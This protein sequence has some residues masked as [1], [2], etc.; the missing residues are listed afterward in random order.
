MTLV[1]FYARSDRPEAAALA[2]RATSWL[3]DRGHQAISARQPDGTVS[4]DGADLLVSLGGDGTLL[5]AV[6]SVSQTGIP[7]LG[8]NMGRLGYLTQVEPAGLEPALDR[9]LAGDRTQ[10]VGRRIHQLRVL[11]RLAEPDI[12]RDFLDL[13]HGHDIRVAELLHQGRRHRFRV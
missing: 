1:A 6:E 13:R 9:F 2:E 8:V 10:F 11:R 3:V 4:M 5:R 12:E 7:V